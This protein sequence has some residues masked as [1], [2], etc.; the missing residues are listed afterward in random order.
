MESR[1]RAAALAALALGAYLCNLYDLYHTLYALKHL[2]GVTEANPFCRALLGLPW[3][4]Q[5]YKC[6]LVPAGL[7]LLWCRRD[8]PLAR[9]GLCL[10]AAVFFLNT[11][12]QLRMAQLYW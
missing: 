1:R 12:C 4:L 2:W 11:L 6:A 9:W 3:G 7:Y 10:C 8:L 5:V